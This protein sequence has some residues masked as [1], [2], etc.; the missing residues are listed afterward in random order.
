MSWID[1]VKRLRELA[2]DDENESISRAIENIEA[3]TPQV[4]EGGADAIG[5]TGPSPVG[6]VNPEDKEEVEEAGSADIH[7]VYEL[8]DD[9]EE[10]LDR[11]VR[12]LTKLA[13][14]ARRAR[15]PHPF[16][17]QIESYILPHLKSWIS[18]QNQPGSLATLRRILSNSDEE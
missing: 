15:V 9:V 17:A 18:D 11:S 10:Y 4:K 8:L 6:S 5:Q 3:F 7:M 16:D 12:A 13:R 14:E 2:E 1:V